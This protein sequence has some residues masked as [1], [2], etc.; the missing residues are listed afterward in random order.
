LAIVWFVEKTNVASTTNSDE[1]TSPY[2]ASYISGPWTEP[3]SG[4]YTAGNIILVNPTSHSFSNL[5]LA[6]QVD[7]S[8]LVNPRMSLWDSN[9]TLNPPNSFFQSVMLFEDL[10]NF[11]TPI[12][13]MTIEPNQK[14][15]LNINIPSTSSFQFSSHD[16]KIYVSQ[17]S[18]GDIINGQSL[19]VPQ[20]EA[21]LKIV[22]F[23]ATESDQDTYRQYYNSTLNSNMVTVAYNPNFY[24]RYWNT[25]KQ[26]YYSDIFGIMHYMSA[27]DFS[28]FNVTVFNNSTFPV[29]SV[30]L[31]ISSYAL[32]DYV[33]QPNE[34]Y[35]FPVKSTEYPSSNAYA[36]GY[37]INNPES[38]TPTPSVPELSLFELLP[39]FSF[40]V[41]SAVAVRH[42]LNNKK[43]HQDA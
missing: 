30:T 29:N 22:N 26:D 9:Y 4:G 15:T 35:L 27:L 23:S 38:P 5:T 21:Y 41:I 16:L 31:S 43:R 25:S 19:T 24:Q 40:T 7:N 20:T 39:L 37:I 14:E 6:I 32:H 18:F 36:T 13:S 3:T 11:S 10:Q 28:Y 8:D 33:M 34:T 42:R 1:H 17:N 2:I 12:T